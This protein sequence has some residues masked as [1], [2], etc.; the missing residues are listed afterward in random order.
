MYR[1][2][3]L[4]FSSLRCVYKHLRPFSQAN[5]FE[6]SRSCQV[7]LSST[8]RDA[9][10]QPKG[11]EMLSPG[12]VLSGQ[13]GRDFTVERV[14]QKKEGSP[15][16][17]YL[18]TCA[19]EKFILKDVAD[20]EYLGDIYS[21]VDPCPYLR[22]PQD[23]VPSRSM[24][25]YRFFTDEFLS[26]AANTDLPLATTKRI[27]KDA[28]RGLAALHEQN[29]VHNDVKP[30]NI[31][32]DRKDDK[33]E[34]V[35]LGDIEDAA[36]VPPGTALL[37]R[38]LGNWMWRSPEAHAEGPMT[39]PSDIFSFGIVCIY[40]V[41]KRIMFAVDESELGPGEEILAHVLERQ[42]SFFADADGIQGFIDLIG[43]NDS[44]YTEIFRVIRDGFNAENPW[45]QFSLWENVDPVFKDLV[46]RM[47]VFDPVKR[48]TARDALAHPWF[49]GV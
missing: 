45:R 40:A 12:S 14:L 24:Y 35:Q 17:V 37:G 29:I 11:R 34:C 41:H 1:P 25:A 3:A 27:L 26:L 39:T 20:F 28:L 38:Q 31:L 46:C 8:H 32:V 10:S 42:I 19:N 48:I 7:R 36:I 5:P 22:L 9:S 2:Q 21:K 30:N 4:S 18:A 13:S 23:T 15:L 16:G 47:T 44:P 33:I 43:R 6:T 49:E